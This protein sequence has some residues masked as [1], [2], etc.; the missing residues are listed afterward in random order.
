MQFV[1]KKQLVHGS[2]TP[3]NSS[4][5][6][7][8]LSKIHILNTSMADVCVKCRS[9][10]K[11]RKGEGLNLAILTGK[12]GENREVRANTCKQL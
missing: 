10:W 11:S 5:N 4:L 8:A 3:T 12:R 9:C 7:I 1:S 6:A 2:Q